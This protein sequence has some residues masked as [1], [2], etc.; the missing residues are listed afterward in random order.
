MLSLHIAQKEENIFVMMKILFSTLQKSYL[1]TI[2]C[3]IQNPFLF[4]FWLPF[5]FLIRWDNTLSS[6]K[7]EDSVCKF[8]ELFHDYT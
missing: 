1:S 2:M 4:V 7:Y 5:F 6:F 8:A 3:N